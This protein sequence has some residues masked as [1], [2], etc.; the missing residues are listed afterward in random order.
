MPFIGSD[1]NI[2]F[3]NRQFG[4][5]KRYRTTRAPTTADFR[6]FNLMDEWLH[7][8]EDQTMNTAFKLVS[9][10]NGIATWVNLTGTETVD[11]TQI[12]VDAGTSPVV[13]DSSGNITLTG[14][15]GRTFT[16]GVNTI[17][18]T[19]LRDLSS[20]VVNSNAGSEHLTIQD[21]IDAA[22]SASASSSNFKTVLV[23]TG[24][25]GTYT[26]SITLADG[27]NLIAIGIDGFIGSINIVGIA[28]NPAVRMPATG[29]FAMQG[30]RI[31]SQA[32]EDCI[33]EAATVTGNVVGEI[34][35]CYVDATT[36]AGTNA[37]NVNTGVATNTIELDVKNSR[38]TGGTNSALV[39]TA[40]ASAS[41]SVKIS[42]DT[43]I[44]SDGVPAIKIGER[45]T[46][47]HTFSEVNT[48]GG[49]TDYVEENAPADVGNYVKGSVLL[50]GT[51]IGIGA[52]IAPNTTTILQ[53]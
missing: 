9:K 22:I 29:R 6:N 45:A 46:V 28:S 36:N 51:V 20:F 34:N 8:M 37:V 30:F 2:N 10:A 50:S 12:I 26:E 44:E 21:G 24:A 11:I 13:P 15:P 31:Q 5:I 52:T 40:I 25:T 1:A 39:A 49:I 16:G 47:T 48:I 38:L 42:V 32:G 35:K 14:V 3:P 18:L 19:D 7:V 53:V 17:T 43:L 33:R 23:T 4:S 27:I 41:A